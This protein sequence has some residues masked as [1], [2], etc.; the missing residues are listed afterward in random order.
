MTVI[1]KA[2]L[3]FCIAMI[4]GVVLGITAAYILRGDFSHFITL[5]VVNVWIGLPALLIGGILIFIGRIRRKNR[6]M[7]SGLFIASILISTLTAIPFLKLGSYLHEKDIDK[8]KS[9]H[10]TSK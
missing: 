4:T 7:T 3:I 1:K 10:I 9:L 2:G 8:A 6:V 5:G